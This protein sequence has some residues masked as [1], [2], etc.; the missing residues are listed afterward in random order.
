MAE[1]RKIPINPE[2]IESIP[3]QVLRESPEEADVVAESEA[4]RVLPEDIRNL[5][6]RCETAEKRVAE[7]HDQLIRTLADFNN[8]RRRAREELDQARQFAIEDF[9]IRLLP[10]MD[11]F[12]RAI[13]TAEELN[14]FD[15]LHGGVV[16]IL[17][18]LKDVLEKEGVKP[19]EAEG[20]EFDPAVHEAAMRVDTD[21][22]PDG[23][24]IE[25][26]QK[27]YILGDKVIRPSMVKVARH[28]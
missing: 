20:Q 23:A 17:R 4:E 1:K 22:Y 2:D 6:E 28:P 3:K 27:G 24:I 5:M 14:E 15:A 9:A 13:K 26:F 11:N 10:V 7:E 19:I 21:E 8:Y 25:E 18:Q 16:L 12:E